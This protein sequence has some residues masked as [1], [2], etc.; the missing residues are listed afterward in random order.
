MDAQLTIRSENK[1]R[2]TQWY[3]LTSYYSVITDEMTASGIQDAIG[4]YMEAK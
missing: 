4:Q 1:N 2:Y 3:E